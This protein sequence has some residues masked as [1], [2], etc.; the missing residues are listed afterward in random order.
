MPQMIS[1]VDKSIISAVMAELASRNKGIPKPKARKT[2]KKVDG[3]KG[4]KIKA[5]TLDSVFRLN[6]I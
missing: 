1:Q 5:K 6:Y 3:Q 4:L 2:A